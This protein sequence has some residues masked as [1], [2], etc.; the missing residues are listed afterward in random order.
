MGGLQ[1]LGRRHVAM[2]GSKPCEGV[3][4]AEKQCKPTAG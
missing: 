4:G 3:E 2:S 1:L